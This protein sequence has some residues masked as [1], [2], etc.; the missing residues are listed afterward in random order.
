[1]RMDF[2]PFGPPQKI[3]QSESNFSD[4]GTFKKFDNNQSESSFT[5]HGFF[6]NLMSTN[7]NQT[8][9]ILECSNVSI[10]NNQNPDLF[11]VEL[12]KTLTHPDIQTVVSLYFYEF[13]NSIKNHYVELQL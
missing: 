13:L 7:Q 10:T 1:M 8:F 9:L 3:M 4:H 12:S 6:K 5:N 2:V 11:I